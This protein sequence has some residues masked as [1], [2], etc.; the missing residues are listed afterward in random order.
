[1]GSFKCKLLTNF[2][3]KLRRS[4]MSLGNTIVTQNLLISQFPSLNGI[5]WMILLSVKDC[6]KI[7]PLILSKLINFYPPWN[8]QKTIG[9]QTQSSL[10]K[11]SFYQQKNHSSFWAGLKQSVLSF[12]YCLIG[13]VLLDTRHDG[14]DLDLDGLHGFD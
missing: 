12:K 8:H 2:E 4:I 6:L 10:L 9:R 1:M 14:F 13:L 7:L 11:T 3:Q 5:F